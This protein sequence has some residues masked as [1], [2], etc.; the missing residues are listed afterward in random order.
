MVLFGALDSPLPSELDSIKDV[1]QELSA[2]SKVLIVA[3]TIIFVVAFFGCWGAVSDSSCM[4]FLV[5]TQLRWS[6]LKTSVCR[7]EKILSFVFVSTPY[8]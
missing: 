5:S 7:M 3:G 6:W 1:M 2:T 8:S 4:L